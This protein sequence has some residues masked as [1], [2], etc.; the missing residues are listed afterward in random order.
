MPEPK[1]PLLKLTSLATGGQN[2]RRMRL[3][4]GTPHN[5]DELLDVPHLSYSAVKTTS[6]EQTSKAV[7][8]MQIPPKCLCLISFC[9]VVCMTNCP[10]Q[11]STRSVNDVQSLHVAQILQ[12]ECLVQTWH[13]A[14]LGELAHTCSHLRCVEPARHTSHTCVQLACDCKVAFHTCISHCQTQMHIK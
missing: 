3:A 11:L 7:N 4:I 9:G 1:K 2:R 5:Q 8:S 6:T 12:D 14:V 10:A 13:V